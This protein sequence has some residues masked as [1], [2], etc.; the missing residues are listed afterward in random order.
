MMGRFAERSSE[1]FFPH[2][3]RGRHTN[4]TCEMMDELIS[5][6]VDGALDADYL[7]VEQHIESCQACREALGELRALSGACALAE[8]EPPAGLRQGILAAV[9]A[10]AVCQS[11]ASLLP[12]AADAS[13][14]PDGQTAV[15]AHVQTCPA[16]AEELEQY[17]K[18]IAAVPLAEAAAPGGL[19]DRIARGT[20]GRVTLWSRAAGVFG[21]LGIPVRTLSAAGACAIAALAWSASH[22]A[23]VDVA[24]PAAT[25]RVQAAVPSDHIAREASRV[26]ERE[27]A[28]SAAVADASAV[29]P[30]VRVSPRP[31]QNWA[32]EAETQAPPAPAQVARLPLPAVEKTKAP[33]TPSDSDLLPAIIETPVVEAPAKDVSVPAPAAGTIRLAQVD[34][35]RVF[36]GEEVDL[37]QRVREIAREREERAAAVRFAEVA[38]GN[39]VTIKFWQARF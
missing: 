11:F 26:G 22:R 31:L 9:A 18:V 15:N 36:E 34:P 16:C 13:L 32:P 24:V 19:R 5:C 20:Y 17:E 12:L 33:P 21:H 6:Y 35:P 7:L 37:S 4:M 38:P 1:P 25:V 14:T 30:P 2:Y 39:K 29:R 3:H 10:S 8:S 23:P 27:Q 28:L